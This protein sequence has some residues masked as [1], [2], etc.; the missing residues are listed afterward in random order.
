MAKLLGLDIGEKRIGVSLG[1]DRLNVCWPL[2]TIN[3]TDKIESEIIKL[4]QS[5]QAET[6]VVG[7]PRNQSG[8]MTAQTDRVQKFVH[9][10]ELPADVKIVWQDESLTSKRAEEELRNRG[11]PFNKGD[12]DSLAA[13]YILEDYL[14]E[15]V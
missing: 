15:N 8:G 3:V 14:G 11:K 10:L 6:I 9:D 7:L 13:T 12:I 1:D 2:M 4:I 5:Q